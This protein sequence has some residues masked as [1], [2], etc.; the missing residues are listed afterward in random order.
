MFALNAYTKWLNV[1]PYKTKM[2]TS[3]GIFAA[4][5]VIV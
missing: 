1:H 2:I 5:D 4:A 3:G